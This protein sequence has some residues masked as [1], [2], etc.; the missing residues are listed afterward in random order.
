ML[1]YKLTHHDGSDEFK[2]G[3]DW[4]FD[5]EGRP[6][7][8]EGEDL[9]VQEVLKILV[10]NTQAWGYGTANSLALGEKNLTAKRAFIMFESERAL[11]FLRQLQQSMKLRESRQLTELL[12]SATKVQVSIDSESPVSVRVNLNLVLESGKSVEVSTKIQ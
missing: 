3:M 12:N 1:D 7:S 4:T 8:V 6:N 9:L 10:T 2:S 11:L 5:G